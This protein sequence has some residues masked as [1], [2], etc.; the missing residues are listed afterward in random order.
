MI[1]WVLCSG[2]WGGYRNVM[3]IRVMDYMSKGT[4]NL[5]ME[6]AIRAGLKLKQIISWRITRCV[7]ASICNNCADWL[8]I[9]DPKTRGFLIAVCFP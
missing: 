4:I 2:I 9:A 7:K 3:K 1:K 5:R 8:K 6:F